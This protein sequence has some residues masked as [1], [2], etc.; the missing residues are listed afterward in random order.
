[1][2]ECYGGSFNMKEY[3]RICQS[4]RKELKDSHKKIYLHLELTN[5][6]EKLT[7]AQAIKKVSAF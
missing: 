2:Y 6:K 3:C 7:V 1:M 4:Q 5:S